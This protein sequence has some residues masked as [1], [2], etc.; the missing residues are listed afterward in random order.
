MPGGFMLRVGIVT[1]LVFIQMSRPLLAE[2]YPSQTIRIVVPFG[3]AGSPDVLARIVATRLSEKYGKSAVV[4]NRPGANGLIAGGLVKHAKP[5]GHTLLLGNTGLLAINKSLYSKLP[6]EPA[7][8]F[9]PITQIMA[10]TFFV[11]AHTNLQVKSVTDLINVM[12]KKPSAL[13]YA[14]PGHGSVHH[15]CLALFLN[16]S[17][18]D[19][20]HVP[21]KT[22]VDVGKAFMTDEVELTCSG[23]GAM[24][25]IVSTKKAAPLV[26]ALERRSGLDPQVP[27]LK[28]AAGLD[29]FEIGSQLGILA[30]AGTPRGIVDQLSKDIADSLQTPQA[31][32]M[33]SAQGVEVV[34][35]GP[36]SYAA[37]IHREIG[38]F[39][40][41]VRLTGAS[42]DNR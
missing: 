37:L 38:Q 21:F 41:L 24:Q 13:N 5:D 31:Q 17:G 7:K 28:E 26:V 9:A 20:V 39:E 2:S 4:E 40:R 18:T 25:S 11:Y 6:Y 22:T 10:S 8:D 36:D 16:I 15:M 12:K 1:A 30:P 29:G 32:S 42:I 27:T 3:P 33:M 14:S 35:E 23:K 19:A 34:T